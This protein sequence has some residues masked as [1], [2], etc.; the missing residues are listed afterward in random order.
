MTVSSRKSNLALARYIFLLALVPVFVATGCD[1][2]ASYVGD[3]SASK[4]SGPP[5]GIDGYLIELPLVCLQRGDSK[6]FLIERFPQKGTYYVTVLPAQGR[7]ETEMDCNLEVYKNENLE[8]VM[9]SRESRFVRVEGGGIFE[10]YLFDTD[11]RPGYGN[12]TVS[13][14]DEEYRLRFM[15]EGWGESAACLDGVLR[16]RVG[17]SK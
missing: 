1:Q 5:L 9:D 17:G 2:T 10:G 12:I 14:L 16:L 4:L 8:Q 7:E 6:D 11:A 13:S 15:F 3:G